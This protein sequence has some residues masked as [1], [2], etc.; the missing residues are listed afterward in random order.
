MRIERLDIKGF[1]KFNNLK[2]DFKEGFNVVYGKNE[3]GKTTLQWFIK[4]MLFGLKGGRSGKDGSLPPSKRFKPWG[5]KDYS[6]VL[7]YRLENGQAFRVGRNFG[8]NSVNIYDSLFNDLT[9]QF[10]TSRERGALFAEKQLGVNENCFEKTVLIR[11]METR[12]DED[13]S[14]EL[15]NRLTNVMESGFEDISYRRAEEA[16]KEALK[17]EI[18]TGKT[19]TRPLDKINSRLDELTALKNEIIQKRL[20]QIKTEQELSNKNEKRKELEERKVLFNKVKDYLLLKKE[21]ELLYKKRTVLEE[22]IN[23]LNRTALDKGNIQADISRIT[24]DKEKL[25]GY[26]SF[27]NEDADNITIDYNS[28]KQLEGENQS[29][30]IQIRQ[31]EDEINSLRSSI[32]HLGA[33]EIPGSDTETVKLA[34]ELESMESD[35]SRDDYDYINDTIQNLKN[36]KKKSRLGT[37]LLAIT[38]A[39][40]LTAGLLTGKG[41]IVWYI[42]FGALLISA[43]IFSGLFLKNSRALKE[44]EG[45]KK[46]SFIYSRDISE[47]IE[48]KKKKLNEKLQSV[49]ATNLEDYLQFKSIYNKSILEIRLLESKLEDLNK[50]ITANNNNINVYKVSILKKLESAGIQISEN[51]ISD[52]TI[53]E[54]KNNIRRFKE[55]EP[56]LDYAQKKLAAISAEADNVRAVLKPYDID[57][58]EC[59]QLE[60]LLNSIIPEI[61]SL[62]IKSSELIRALEA[63]MGSTVLSEV[64]IS[65]IKSDITNNN[66]ASSMQAIIDELEEINTNINNI[67]LEIRGLETLL[68][69]SEADTDTLQRI[70][71]EACELEIKKG[72]LTDISSSIKTALEVLSE[73]SSE[74][75]KDFVPVLNNKMSKIIDRI[76]MGRYL[77]LRANDHL[78]LNVIAPETGDVVPASLLSSGTADQMYLALRL[79]MADFITSGNEKLPLLLDEIFS[80]FDDTRTE[81]TLELLEELAEGTQVILFTCKQ[82]ELEAAQLQFKSKLNTIILP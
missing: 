50:T 57:F 75:Q 30:L 52:K 7:E 63:D 77:D 36:S 18:G 70:E 3:S 66:T 10:E 43:L 65:S 20:G 21:L 51:A 26:S 22:S 71:E 58:D 76:S 27:E 60:K 42:A 78:A 32:K 12:I 6:G 40:T 16:L 68:N 1:G 31:K 23:R 19:T 64:A 44:A 49:G 73:A 34:A 67:S 53:N 41:A 81:Q 14:K 62:E 48:K 33:F 13:G 28:M 56:S 17:S 80:Q 39:A 45:K 72:Q 59:S 15:L 8:N 2:L 46:I 79:A 24:S 38:S 74:I 69:S 54:F 61:E 25:I 29:T 37:F 55:L 35:K 5:S 11:Q 47:Q 82:R 9:A 4:G